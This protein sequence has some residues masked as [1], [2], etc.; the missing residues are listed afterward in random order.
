[1]LRFLASGCLLLLAAA[2]AAQPPSEPAAPPAEA[3]PGQITRLPSLVRFVEAPYPPEAER[4]GLEGSVLLEIDLGVDGRV[5]RAEVLEPAGHGFDEAALEAVRQFEFVPAEIDHVPSA[6]RLTYRYE[7]VLRA[8]E[9]AEPTEDG[10]A[11]LS[12]EG[13]LLERG[14][15]V[16]LKEAVISARKGDVLLEQTT[17]REGRFQFRGLEPGKWTFAVTHPGFERFTTEE[18][19]REGE[20]ATATYYVL[21]RSHGL[22]VVVRAPREKKEVARRTVTLEEARR[23]PGTFGDAIRVVQNLPGVART[24]LGLG[25]L[26]VRGGRPGDTRTY[27]DGQYVPI[28]FHFGGLLSVI[29]SDL[30]ESLDFYPGSPPVRYGRSI[31]G[32]VDVNTRRASR[33]RLRGYAD[34]SLGETSLLLESPLGEKGAFVAS[35]RRSYI[36]VVLPAVLRFTG[37]TGVNAA[38]VYW[39]YQLK[40]DFDVGKNE[41]SFFLFGSDDRLNVVLDNPAA[42]SATSRGGGLDNHIGFHRFITEWKRKLT[43]TID[44][45]AS[46]TLGT[47]R[48]ANKIGE[49]VYFLMDLQTVGL[50]EDLSFRF[51]DS[52]RLTVGADVLGYGYAYKVQ[53]PPR[54]IPGEIMDP[55]VAD[56]LE[57]SSDKGFF[58]LP[59]LFADFVWEPTERLRLV[60]G[61]RVDYDGFLDRTWFDPRLSAFYKLTDAVS[62]KASTGLVHQPPTPEKLTKGF[63]NPDLNE[64]GAREYAAGVE[65]RFAERFGVDVQVYFRDLFGVVGQVPDVATNPDGSAA[66]RVFENSDEGRAYGIEVLLRRD[67][68]TDLFGWVAVSLGQSERRRDSSEPWMQTA[69]NQRYNVVGVLSYRTPWQVEVG[70][71]IR[72]T[73]GNPYTAIC[74]GVYNADADLYVPVPCPE[75][76]ALR[77]PAFFQVDLRIDR[78]WVFDTWM[79]NAYVDILNLTNQRNVESLTYNFDY[80]ESRPVYGLPLFPSFG[81]RGEF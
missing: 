9:I 74:K 29:N 65:W 64:E 42:V 69:L 52:A 27:I 5:L 46:L 54:P 34:V 56:R 6:V 55:N 78:K 50:R 49:F 75:R 14:T 17:D 39:D 60:P 41:L 57:I 12:L 72:Y 31:A 58:L 33:E 4:E 53:S 28:L 68:G 47:G 62:L 7:F 59:A 15:R 18:E 45:R 21:R 70:T 13:R 44:H 79:L 63:A 73:D 16:A 24:P 35:A 66:R 3:A 25:P 26:I 20:I 32:A 43:P 36:D 30:M 61:V 22:E 38:P 76:R 80:S 48:T 11:A 81:I 19:I 71:R 8:P 1:M 23:I 67:P 77:H 37:T 2:A 40:G 51:S 10:E